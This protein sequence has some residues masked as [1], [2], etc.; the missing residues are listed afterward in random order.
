MAQPPG[1]P[2]GFNMFYPI[3]NAINNSQEVTD[4]HVTKGH[5]KKLICKRGSGLL[6]VVLLRVRVHN[7]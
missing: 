3:A 7:S 6:K 1:S 4:S 2:V 5:S